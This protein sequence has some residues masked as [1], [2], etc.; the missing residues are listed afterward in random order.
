MIGNLKNLKLIFFLNS[1]NSD[2]FPIPLDWPIYGFRINLILRCFMKP[3]HGNLK[4][5]FYHG[6]SY[7]VFSSVFLIL[8]HHQKFQ[9]LATAVIFFSKFWILLH[10]LVN[11]TYCMDIQEILPFPLSEK[12]IYMYTFQ[13]T[14][15]FYFWKHLNRKFVS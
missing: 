1:Q 2:D 15:T 4:K 7:E 13:K 3:G 14:L 5:N 11:W 10:F 6:F 8:L 12:Y 9:S